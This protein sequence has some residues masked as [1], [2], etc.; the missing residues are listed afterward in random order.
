MTGRYAQLVSQLLA[1][2]TGT[3][4]RVPLAT[5]QA[6]LDRAAGLVNAE[7]V[8]PVDLPADLA[9]HVDAVIQHAYRVTDD[10]VARLSS[11]GHSDDAIFEATVS[12]A[13]GAGTSR[14]ARALE[15]LHG[16]R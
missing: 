15:L 12:A 9:R 13:V 4:G 3:P 16:D 11:A 10:D 7:P 6:I 5:R 1:S 14:L 8:A 2:V